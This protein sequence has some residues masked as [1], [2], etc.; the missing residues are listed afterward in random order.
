MDVKTALEMAEEWT[1]GCTFHEH[2]QGWRIVC[3][4][5][6]AEVRKL[7]IAGSDLSDAMVLLAEADNIMAEFKRGYDRYEYVRK[8]TPVTF[9][10][11]W[12]KNI[13]TG[14]EFDSLVDEARNESP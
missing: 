5:L 4:V 7:R 14:Q 12:M 13:E 11:L 3:A 9:H 8:L 6:A 10:E 2:S 1:K